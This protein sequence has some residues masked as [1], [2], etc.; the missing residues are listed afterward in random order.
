MVKA[1]KVHQ[2]RRPRRGGQIPLWMMVV[3]FA[4]L[5][6]TV[7]IWTYKSTRPE[8]TDGRETIVFWNAASFGTDVYTS[9]HQFELENRQYK[10]VAGSTVSRDLTADAQRLLCAVAGEVP[11][12]L[13]LFDR[14]AIGEWAGRG[15]MTDLNPYLDDPKF[16]NPTDPYYINRKD[17]YDWAMQEATYKPPG[18][19]QKPGLFG[20]PTGIDIRLLYSNT[21]LLQQKELQPPNTWD[22]L[23]KDAKLLTT[24]RPD[25][26]IKQLGFAPNY[27]NS[28]L[29]MYAFQAG[30]HLLN[31]ETVVKDGRTYPPRTL[32]TLDSP[33]VARALRFM[34]DIYDEAGGV[35]EVDKFSSGFQSDSLDP[36][37]SNQ[38]ALKIDGDWGM[39][40][41]A[42][43]K[44]NL[45]FEITPA[46]MPDDVLNGRPLKD[47]AITWAGGYSMVIPSTSK[48]KTGAFKLMQFMLSSKTYRFLN[49]GDR[50]TMESQGQLYLPHPVANRVI[51]KQEMEQYVTHNKDMPPPFRRAYDTIALMLDRTLIRPPSPVGQ[52]LWNKHIDAM[53]DALAHG[54]WS[55]K[56]DEQKKCRDHAGPGTQ[57]GGRAAQARRDRRSASTPRGR[58]GNL[59]LCLR[60]SG[61]GAVRGLDAGR[62]SWPAL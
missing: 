21:N 13:V 23:Q 55:G 30:G 6:V 58:L 54:S 19:N 32:V 36:F 3:L 53:N 47:G 39:Q 4:L 11:P 43:W 48:N 40:T 8:T 41:I 10:V 52:L 57:P 34:T 16:N 44:P 29:Y 49:E 56:T 60:P 18:T 61:R 59:L 37:L 7:S 45:N 31:E 5:V 12:D 51:L 14:F 33:P 38:I 50:Q 20:V 26:T 9:I 46:P 15:A 2:T 22:E 62:A 35:K 24:H 17:F 28:W 42:K 1:L 27:G 25:G